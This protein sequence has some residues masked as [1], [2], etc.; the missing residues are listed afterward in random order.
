MTPALRDLPLRLQHDSFAPYD[1]RNLGLS[2][3]RLRRGD[4]AHPF[5]G[6]SAHRVDLGDIVQRAAALTRRH[7]M[8]P[9]VFSHLTAARLLG[10]PLPR[11]SRHDNL[12]ITVAHPARAPRLAGVE[13]HAFRH[14]ARAVRHSRFVSASSGEVLLL[15]V[16]RDDW[17]IASLATQLE[18]D[19]LVAVIDSVQYRATR[20]FTSLG[21]LSPPGMPILANDSGCLDLAGPLTKGRRGSHQA[22][23]ALAL[24]R[25]GARSRP[26]TF[27]RLLIQRAGFPEP[28]LGHS[29]SGAGWN[30]I[31]DLAWPA[32]SVL[33]EYEGDHHRTNARQFSHDI[34]RFERYADCGWSAMRVTRRDLFEHTFELISR[35]ENRLR[36]TGWAPARSWHS[37]PVAPFRP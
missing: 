20:Q 29:I 25:V 26:E 35:V 15:P 32:Y 17:L 28:A 30:A 6:V 4:I 16:F 13:A 34:R 22:R 36:K 19:D 1:L 3:E 5:H 12:Q 8:P 24:S 37:R 9:F 31:P 21:E 14:P 33:L 27:L 2:T 11:D 18:C 7:D 23:R 10:L